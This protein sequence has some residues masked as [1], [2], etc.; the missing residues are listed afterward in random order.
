VKGLYRNI[1]FWEKIL[2]NKNMNMSKQIVD[3]FMANF[4]LDEEP[5]I[6]YCLSQK[7]LIDVIK[8]ACH[9]VSETN[10]KNRHQNR[11]K[12]IILREFGENLISIVSDLNN[13]KDFETLI[14]FIYNR[15]I[16]GIGKLAVYDIALR[17]GYYLKKYPDEV[18]LHAGTRVGAEI[19]LGK[20]IIEK[21]IKKE[22]LT[23]IYP[24]LERLNCAE[25][26][27]FLCVFHKKKQTKKNLI[28]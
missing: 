26:E 16:K 12:A 1:Y 13:A 25:L 14:N 27:V 20:K 23:K 22:E 19:I 3:D 28:C 8:V 21:S 10:R 15:K 17:I 18:Y 7:N 11:I 6:A 5:V 2:Q 4:N 24:A 9:S